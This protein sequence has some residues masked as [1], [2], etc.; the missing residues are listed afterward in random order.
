MK[1]NAETHARKAR[2]RREQILE[3]ISDLWDENGVGPTIEEVADRCE[4]G[5]ATI[6]RAVAVLREDGLLEPSGGQPRRLR[7]AP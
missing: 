3:A 2:E 5:R 1:A 6:V 7:P 4:F